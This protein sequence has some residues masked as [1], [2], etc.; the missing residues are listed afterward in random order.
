MTK[1]TKTFW[2]SAGLLAGGIAMSAFTDLKE[3]GAGVIAVGAS[4]LGLDMRRRA[5][6][7]KP[8]AKLMK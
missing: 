4:G 1:K 6:A 2:I 7:K 3:Y 8:T 5:K